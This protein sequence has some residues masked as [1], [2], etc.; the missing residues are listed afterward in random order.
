[1]YTVEKYEGSPG[2]YYQNKGQMNLYNT[3]WSVVV[4]VNLKKIDTQ[5]QGIEQ[6][7][8]HV[9][10]LCQELG[11]QN[12]TDCHHFQEIADDKLERIKKTE[13]LLLDISMKSEKKRGIFN[14][15]SH[16][17]KILFGT[18]DNDDAEYYNE[19]IK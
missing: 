16:I 8:K 3:Q 19:Q 18:M 9:N 12:W 10:K 14:F 7:I 6:Y 1:D 17:S 5:S 13:E 4:Y 2:I 11:V 15:I